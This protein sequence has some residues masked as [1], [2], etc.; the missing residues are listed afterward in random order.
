MDA[1]VDYSGGFRFEITARGHRIVSDQPLSNGGADSGMTPPELLLASLG[2][3]AGYYA[4]EYLRVRSLPTDGLRVF[5]NAEKA[6]KPARLGMF[7]IRVEAPSVDPSH[8]EMLLRTV[9]HCLV[10]NTLLQAPAIE[11]TIETGARA[12]A[13]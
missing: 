9:K 6:L 7:R 10:H 8:R 12:D 5:V 1:Q 4:A 13:A 11:V 2:S 3:C